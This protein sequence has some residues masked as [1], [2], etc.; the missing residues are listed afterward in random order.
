LSA[1]VLSSVYGLDTSRQVWDS[2]ATR[3]ASHSRSRISYLKKQLQTL[4][5]GSK[6]CTEFLT[7]AKSW[8]DQL[9]AVGKP[10]DDDD[11]ISYIMSGLNPSYISFISSFNLLTRQ[12]TVTLEDFQ[13]ELLNHEILLA[14]QQHSTDIDS[15]NFALFTQK[16]KPMIPNHKGKPNN[17]HRNSHHFS[18]K[19]PEGNNTFF[20]NFSSSVPYSP[21]R[22]KI[23][24]QICGKLGHQALDC[25]HRMNY[26]YQGKHPPAQ[27]AA[28]AAKTNAQADHSAEEP[29]YADSGAN[30]HITASLDNLHIQEPYKG[31][32]E[33]A[34]GNGSGLTIANTGSITLYNSKLPFHL[35]H[36]LHCP[37]AAANLLSIQKFCVDNHCWFKLTA[38]HYFV[39]DNLTG[40]TL[41]QGR[42]RDGLYPIFLTKPP[43]KARRLTAF[44][45][46][47]A[48]LACWHRRLGHPSLSIIEQLR[49]LGHLSVSALTN[50]HS[51]CEPCQL[52]KSKCLPF[53]NSNN[54]TSEPLELIHSDLWCSPIPSVSG[55][56]YYV[57]FI[58]NFSR[59]SWIYPMHN[60]SDTFNCFVKFKGIVENLMSKKIKAF[61]SDGGGEFTSNQFKQFLT[62]HGILHR[63]ACPHT[64]QQNGLAERKHR[65]IVETGLALLAQSKLPS[66][67]WVDAFNTAVYLIN[68]MPTSVLHNRSPYFNLLQRN[69]NYSILR[70]FGCS[71]YPLLRPYNKYK[72][73]FRSKRCIFLGY[74][75]NYQGY[76]CLDPATKRL[77]I[78]RHVVFDE[79][80]FPAQDW[81][82]SLQS[83]SASGS[84]TSGTFPSLNNLVDGL[85]HSSSSPTSPHS[86]SH[87][88]T[89]N[90]ETN[91]ADP[92]PPNSTTIDEPVTPATVET[93]STPSIVLPTV[94]PDVNSPSP[95]VGPPSSSN[96]LTPTLHTF[97]TPISST[98]TENLQD[99]SPSSTNPNPP[100]SQHPNPSHP[101][102]TRSRDGTSCPKSF[103]DFKLYYSTKHPFIALHSTTLPPTPTRVSQAL[104]SPQ[105][106]QAMREEFNA[107]IANHTWNLCPRPLHKNVISN[108]WVFKV[109][110]KADGS[111]DRFKARLVAKGFEQQ[112]GIDFTETF[113]PVIKSSTIRIVL[114]IAVHFDWP[115]RQLDVSNAFLHGSLEEEVFME[116]PHGFVSKEFPNHVCH[117]KKSLYGLKQAPRA[118][119]TKLS[120]TLLHLGFQESKVDYSLF[121]F[122]TSTI[123]LFLLIYVDDIIVTG[124]STTTITN[125][126]LCLKQEF[127]MKD[128]GPLSFFLGIHVHRTADGLHLSQSKYI[129]EILDRANM[130]GAKPSKTPIPAGAKLSQFDGDPLP[131]A[132]EYRQIVGALQ[133]CTLTRPDIAFSVNQLFQFMH[134]PT[135]S[136]WTAAKRVL[137]Y[138]KSSAHHGLF[139]G[140]GSLLLNA[141]SDSDWAGNP[142][143]KRSTTGYAIFLGPC[144]VSWS[145]KK[146]PVVSKSSTEAEYRS[147][148]FA[149]AELYWIRMLLREL[150]LPLKVPPK[151]WCDNIGAL[152]LASNPIFHARTKHVEVDYHFIREKVAR[153]DLVT[154][155][156]STLEQVADIFTKGLTSARF[157]LLRD[158]LKVC[159]S[160]ISLRGAVNK[161][162][163]RSYSAKQSNK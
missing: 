141:Y 56:R 15:G 18:Q 161:E 53:S 163:N 142:D 75:S 103:P 159:I 132:T 68:R 62:S 73:M 82:P 9:R 72:L 37:T 23:P 71:C 22:P 143:D 150:H 52:A 26:T 47:S 115:I 55:C 49:K 151:L 116:Q 162:D 7:Q 34:V 152:S 35:K 86:S 121:T 124:N 149:T 41:L 87:V 93:S 4:Q 36:I 145:A 3:F 98:R 42:S 70:T 63:I 5:Q 107:L 12:T 135:T 137:R 32:E 109:K 44:I 50:Q 134:N 138:L 89:S 123:H 54:V 118:W 130:L 90:S 95:S 10:V 122:H 100:T 25:F 45:G 33:V 13:A 74:S 46:V 78:S 144:L 2:L 43:D 117:L 119:F 69:P 156:L 105:W 157:F 81:M 29:W 125:L 31:D 153:K 83:A 127:A 6:S 108:K 80:T 59:F 58:D 92:V 66:T 76:R 65:H 84:A 27:L 154:Q 17:V 104:Q 133:Y 146:Q 24:C 158:K 131:H 14:N 77:Y 126:I 16:S 1:N 19:R 160:P 67:Y 91:T 114:T 94:Q 128:L 110:Q 113:S 111:L 51:L 102:I 21:N 8:A 30:N 112:D 61:Q 106:N 28:M 39:K 48:D 85:Q 40:L 129:S 140:K 64:P 136:H 147:M 120:T 96:N 101:M 11:L 139:F 97:P 99:S 88:P 57:V 20:K 79:N 148:A 155:Y 60:K 38:N